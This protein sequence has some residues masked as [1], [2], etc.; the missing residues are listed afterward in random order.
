MAT[1]KKTGK[2]WSVR[3][4]Y[5]T[6]TG[7]RKQKRVSGFSS[8]DEAAAAVL[9]LKR[10]SD[11]GIDVNGDTVTCSEL[12]ERWFADRCGGLAPMTRGKYSAAMDTNVLKGD[13][14]SGRGQQM[15]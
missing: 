14:I 9:E 11:A 3:F 8:K 4:Y 7:E 2:T 13:G 12:M 15:S 5:E 10:K 6:E 1:F